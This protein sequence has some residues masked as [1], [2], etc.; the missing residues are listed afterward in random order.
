[1]AIKNGCL[2]PISLLLFT[3]FLSRK[4]GDRQPFSD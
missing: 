3:K 4:T 2:S 1:M